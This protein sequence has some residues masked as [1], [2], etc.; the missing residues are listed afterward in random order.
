MANRTTTRRKHNATITKRGG[1]M[2]DDPARVKK[3]GNRKYRASSDSKRRYCIV[4]GAFGLVSDCPDQ[5][6]RSGIIPARGR[7]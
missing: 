5:Q 2:A 4:L 7:R 6:G 1:E 3:C